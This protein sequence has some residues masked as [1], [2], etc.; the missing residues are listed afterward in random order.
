MASRATEA[1]SIRH[2]A[3]RARAAHR[4]R[5]GGISSAPPPAWR[6]TWNDIDHV[7]LRLQIV[8]HGQ[9]DDV[10]GRQ[11]QQACVSL[12]RAAAE[13]E[14]GGAGDINY[15][16]QNFKRLIGVPSGFQPYVSR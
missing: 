7:P 14:P 1:T 9:R 2:M 3:A 11:K 16:D 8:E 5:A 6:R 13:T 15:Q 4:W 12:A 10:G